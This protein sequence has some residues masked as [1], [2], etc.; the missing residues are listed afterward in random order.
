[1]KAWN[2][3]LCTTREFPEECVQKTNLLLPKQTGGGQVKRKK[4]GIN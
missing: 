3:N 4:G 2:P 1:V